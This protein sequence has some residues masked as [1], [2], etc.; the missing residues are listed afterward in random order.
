[1]S[2]YGTKLAEGFS[3]KMLKHLYTNAPIDEIVNRDYEG[4]I[5]AVGSKL[6]IL[7]LARITEKTYNGS[8]LTPDDLSEINAQL[9]IDQY[10]S[11][12]WREK[13]IDK[14]KSYIKNPKG[15]VLQQT[16]NER[17]KNIM[18]Y[19]LG[20]WADAAAGQW[21]G[22]DYTTGTVA[23]T[24]GTGAV[25]GTGTT[26]TSAMVGKPFKATGHTAWYRVATFTDATHITIEDD[27][28][29]NASS[30]SGGAISAGASYTIQANTAKT[31]DNSTTKFLTMLDFFK[32][33][34]DDAEVPSEDRFV[35]I[36]PVGATSLRNDPGIKLNVPEVYQELVKK[37]LV[38]VI[39]NFQIFEQPSNRFAGDNTNGFH[40]VAG[41][42]SW[43][44]LADKALEVGMEEDLI[45]N[46][47]SAYKDLFVYGGKVAD[48]RRKYAV[49]G[50][51]KFQQ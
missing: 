9:V 40:I 50:F 14:W 7:S 8:N 17:K 36:P 46:F 44:T 20:F 35:F 51:V 12:Y 49:H 22:T 11:F 3:A 28:D 10:K 1:M 16:A 42:K 32:Q 37:G 43:L 33:T 27:S 41:H 15:T 24:T 19:L 2:A 31:I 39:D 13:T 34:L 47:G 38:T 26:F 6:N 21:Y 5:N 4:E 25:V 23:V 18:T 45:G 48:E 29:D 30:Y